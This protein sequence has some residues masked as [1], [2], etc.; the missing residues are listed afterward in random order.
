MEPSAS[1]G[2]TYIATRTLPDGEGAFAYLAV[3]LADN[4][5]LWLTQNGEGL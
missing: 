2:R 4:G 1:D 3:S 5:P